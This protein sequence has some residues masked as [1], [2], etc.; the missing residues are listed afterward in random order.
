ML[1]PQEMWR[2]FLGGFGGQRSR[3]FKRRLRRVWCRS[4]GEVGSI[5]GVLGG[6]RVGGFQI[7]LTIFSFSYL[8]PKAFF[9]RLGINDMKTS[10]LC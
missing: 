9:L 8:D 3:W 2:K 1:D 7:S 6:L 10:P 4:I 5:A